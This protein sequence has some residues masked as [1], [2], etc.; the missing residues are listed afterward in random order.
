MNETM[1]KRRNRQILRVPVFLYFSALNCGTVVN[2]GNSHCWEE[3]KVNMELLYFSIQ[4]EALRVL[5]YFEGKFCNVLGT[6]YTIKIIDNVMN[7][8]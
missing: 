4:Q 1:S 2:S 6:T 3:S 8:L 7:Q 5:N